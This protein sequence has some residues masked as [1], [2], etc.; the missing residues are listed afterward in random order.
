MAKDEVTFNTD[1]TIFWY[2]K[3]VLMERH[4]LAGPEGVAFKWS[5]YALT[6]VTDGMHPVH[7]ADTTE[8]HVWMKKG[9]GDEAHAHAMCEQLSGITG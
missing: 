4:S 9:E 8:T 2:G 7:G 6:P 1:K 5:V 3:T